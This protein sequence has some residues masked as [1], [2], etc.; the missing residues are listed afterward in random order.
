M[1]C[2]LGLYLDRT[3]RLEDT[4]RS[5]R[6]FRHWKTDIIFRKSHTSRWLVVTIQLA[7]KLSSSEV[8]RLEDITGLPVRSMTASWAYFKDVP[9]TDIREAVGWNSQSVFA[10]HFL[11][12]V[13]GDDDLLG[14]R[15]PLVATGRAFVYY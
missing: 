1:S 9:L 7:Y 10:Q 12:D 4:D 13:A 5:G 15:L 6:I 14:S 8:L 11:R 3:A 2:V